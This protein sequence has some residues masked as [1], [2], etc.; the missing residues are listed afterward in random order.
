MTLRE[1]WQSLHAVL[2]YDRGL[3]V[4]H[5]STLRERITPIR[6]QIAAFLADE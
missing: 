6:A 1:F 5:H 2:L 3:A 4:A